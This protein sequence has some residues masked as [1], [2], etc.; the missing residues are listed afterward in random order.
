MQSHFVSNKLEQVTCHGEQTPNVSEGVTKR[1][2]ASS[3]DC[4]SDKCISC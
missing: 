2:S 3:P 4:D 1:L